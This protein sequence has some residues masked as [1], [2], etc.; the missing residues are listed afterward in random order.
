LKEKQTKNIYRSGLVTLV[1]RPNVGKSSILNKI[2]ETE[3]SIVSP[4]V[5]T[6]R[7]E[8]MG[9]YHCPRNR[10][11]IVFCDLPGMIRPVDQLGKYCLK[12]TRKS[13]LDSELIVFIVE[14]QIEPGETDLW[15]AKWLERKFRKVPK[16]MIFNKTD[17]VSSKEQFDQNQKKYYQLF[18]EQNF[19]SLKTSVL[20]EQTIKQ[21]PEKIFDYLPEGPEYFTKEQNTNLSVRF[22]AGELIRK[23]VLNSTKEEIP[24][25]VAVLIE[26]FQER[27]ELCF[28]RGQ[29]A[30]ETQSQKKILIGKNGQLLKKIGT[31]ARQDISKLLDQKVYLELRVKVVPKWR[32]NNA[33]LA[34]LGYQ[35]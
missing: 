10:G 34:K 22:I 17:L 25:A 3:I 29:I 26:E 20:E 2:L 27:K 19:K 7:A 15:I 5:Q 8:I 33:S 16:L 32:K 28:I 18:E 6:T 1:G 23:R 12:V 24:H 31:F 9:V 4:K 14:S 21:I 13:N 35:V 30:C 11:Q